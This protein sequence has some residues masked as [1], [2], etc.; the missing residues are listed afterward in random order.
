[1]T[2]HNSVKKA[3]HHLLAE[4]KTG[5][6]IAPIDAEST[7]AEIWKE[8]GPPPA[9][10]YEPFFAQVAREALDSFTKRITDNNN[11][12]RLIIGESV[13]VTLP[14]TDSH[15]Q[16][17]Q[18][19]VTID[20][21]ETRTETDGTKRIVMRRSSFGKPK[22]K[23]DTE[24]KEVLYALYGE[25]T[26]G[27]SVTL[28]RTYPRYRQ[29]LPILVTATVRKNRITKLHEQMVQIEQGQF[30]SRPD[31]QQ[32]PSCPYVLI[33]PGTSKENSL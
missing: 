4:I 15:A 16:P 27:A 8:H 19:R 11:D 20:E 12:N 21:H 23:P 30:S 31:D 7:L 10:W 14:T 17:R 18:I 1:M 28:T 2:F 26:V 6:P 29:E 25:Q 32:C 3:Q 9:H 5:K 33:C 13:I 24:N 22:E